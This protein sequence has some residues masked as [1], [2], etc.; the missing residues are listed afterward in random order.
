M[1]VSLTPLLLT[2]HTRRRRYRKGRRHG[3]LD[4]SYWGTED[5]LAQFMPRVRKK[6]EL[7]AAGHKDAPKDGEGEGDSGSKVC[8]RVIH[9]GY[10]CVAGTRVVGWQGCVWI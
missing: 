3:L 9:V 2:A 6:P 8:L 7:F 1:C 10:R 5:L 4:G